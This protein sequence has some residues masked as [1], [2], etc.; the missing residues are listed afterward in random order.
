ML[1]PEPAA[2][3]TD[4]ETPADAAGEGSGTLIGAGVC[5]LGAG[6]GVASA[7][8][9]DAAYGVLAGIGGAVGA[10]VGVGLGGMGCGDDCPPPHATVATHNMNTALAKRT[11]CAARVIGSPL[12]RQCKRK[13]EAKVSR[14]SA[15]DRTKR[16]IACKA[17][18]VNA[19]QKCYVSV[20][21][22]GHSRGLPTTAKTR[23]SRP[24]R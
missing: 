4:P 5:P 3:A 2:R 16:Q 7:V 20:R 11:F 21:N 22:T 19:Y 6:V 12:E 18:L 13:R 14:V 8:V 23:S 24:S 1:E 17:T 10:T 9:V 15:S